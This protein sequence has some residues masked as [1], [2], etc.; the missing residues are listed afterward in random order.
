MIFFL[1][2]LLCAPAFAATVPVAGSVVRSK[3]WVIRR[4]DNREEEFIGE[5]R[6]QSAG[7]SLSSDWALFKHADRTWK[8]R[9]SVIAHRRLSDGTEMTA[10]GERAG[11][12]EET[13]RGFL[14]PGPGG[15]VLFTRTP[16]LEAPDHGESGR[17]SWNGEASVTLSGGAKVWGPR[18]E[19]AADTAVYERAASRLT[20][21]GGRPVLHKLQGEWVTA[22]KAD[23]IVA[24]ESP[25][26]MDAHGGVTGWIIFNDRTKFKESAK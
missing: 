9:G 18:L 15:R 22:L 17:V 16:P 24:F 7:S 14:E 6:Y 10:R 5:V 23:E 12:N 11:H 1:L 3:Q 2:A 19:L 13:K 26:R 21:Q 25:R 4:G 20:L 8:A